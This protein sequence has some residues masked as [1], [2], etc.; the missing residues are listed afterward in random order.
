[1]SRPKQVMQKA[2]FSVPNTEHLRRQIMGWDVQYGDTA[3]GRPAP[4]CSQSFWSMNYER[5]YSDVEEI[6]ADRTEPICLS[7]ETWI[8]ALY[9][10]GVWMTLWGYLL[11]MLTLKSSS[12]KYLFCPH[13]LTHMSFKTHRTFFSKRNNPL[14]PQSS[15]S[16]YLNLADLFETLGIQW[17]LFLK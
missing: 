2:S 14:V 9:G 10:N 15:S 1:M 6:N 17:C 3:Q 7:L 4:R 13:L 16:L 12:P 11:Q 8:M 5:E